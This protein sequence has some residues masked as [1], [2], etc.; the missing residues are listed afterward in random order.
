MLLSVDSELYHESLQVQKATVRKLSLKAAF[1]FK[2][3][4]PFILSIIGASVPEE[5]DLKLSL[6]SFFKKGNRIGYV[7]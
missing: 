3:N 2:S 5:A 7:F 4:L 1:L 6:F